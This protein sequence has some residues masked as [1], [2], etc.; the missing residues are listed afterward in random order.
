MSLWEGPQNHWTDNVFGTDTS[1]LGQKN[2]TFVLL[3]LLFRLVPVCLFTVQ[4]GAYCSLLHVAAIT[5]R[6]K[7]SERMKPDSPSLRINTY[8][9]CP[10]LLQ[11]GLCGLWSGHISTSYPVRWL[12]Y[13]F[14][15]FLVITPTLHSGKILIFFLSSLYTRSVFWLARQFWV[16]LEMC[17]T[18]P[19]KATT[20][21]ERHELF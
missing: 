7:C 17:L 20:F 16:Q 15:E 13:C 4:M 9:Y 3:L 8:K 21:D 14:I 11:W 19:I 6:Q 10:C 12:K 1:K 18:F 5:G 2:D